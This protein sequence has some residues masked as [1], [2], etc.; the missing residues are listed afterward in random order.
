MSHGRLVAIEG[1]DGAGTTTQAG[2]LAAAL[3]ERGYDTHQ[4]REP[5]DGPIGLLL[6]EMLGGAHEP[7]DSTTFGLLFAADRADHIQREV[8]PAMARGAVVISDRWY[9]SSLAY[10]GNQEERAW[11]RDLNRRALVPDVTVLL[12]IDPDVA[13]RRRAI[14]G[15]PSE[16]FDAGDLQRQIAAG[17]REVAGELSRHERIVVIDGAAPPDDVAA[18][19]LEAVSAALGGR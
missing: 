5:S 1:I 19:V 4:T 13:E 12:E 18:A 9:H 14:A 17:Y 11:I 3:G 16:L 6:R 10:Q 2:R 8:K 7:V 15:R